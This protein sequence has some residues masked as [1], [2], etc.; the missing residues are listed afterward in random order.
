M[1]TTGIPWLDLVIILVLLW[2][3]SSG[4][5]YLAV[6]VIPNSLSEYVHD[7]RTPEQKKADARAA[8]QEK[9]RAKFVKKYGEFPR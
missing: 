2:A 6:E 4:M 5:L 3:V 1:P 8:K 9:V 7:L